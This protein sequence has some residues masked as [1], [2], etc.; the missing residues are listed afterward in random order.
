[1]RF[2]LFTLETI[3]KATLPFQMS[4]L[5]RE[6]METQPKTTWFIFATHDFKGVCFML[7]MH[8]VIVK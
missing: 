8:H 7:L 3:A 2:S 4:H 1:M 5:P 6:Q